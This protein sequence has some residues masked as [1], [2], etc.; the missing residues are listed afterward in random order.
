MICNLQKAHSFRIM[1]GKCKYA[2]NAQG[3]HTHRLFLLCYYCRINALNAIK[4]NY[5][6][7]KNPPRKVFKYL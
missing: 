5:M 6:D 1:N 2:R 7:L 4:E 3:M